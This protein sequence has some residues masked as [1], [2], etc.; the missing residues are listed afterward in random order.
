[1]RG[2]LVCC[3]LVVVNGAG[4]DV[5]SRITTATFPGIETPHAMASDADGFLY[6][7]AYGFAHQRLEA[8]AIKVRELDLH[9]SEQEALGPAA[10]FVE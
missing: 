1:M 2:M 9:V 4:N 7:S 8:H 6:L 10:H 3:L 5:I